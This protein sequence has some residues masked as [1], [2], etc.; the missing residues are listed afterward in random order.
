MNCKFFELPREK[1]DAII[2][3]G[4]E[5]FAKNTYKKAPMSEIAEAAGISKSLLFHYFVNKKEYYLFLHDFAS[6]Y[7]TEKILESGVMDQTDFFDLFQT[8]LMVKCQIMREHFFLNQFLLQAYFEEEPALIEDIKA[9]T[10]VIL[11]NS[12]HT[13]LERVDLFKFREGTDVKMLLNISIWSAEGYVHQQMQCKNMEVDLWEK[14]FTEVLDFWKKS[15]YKE[16][17]L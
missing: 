11:D 15:H 2:N 3:A 10:S 7:L 12:I 5:I 8:S 13:I 16:E 9:R 6:A 4:C 14:D 17:Y 1:Q